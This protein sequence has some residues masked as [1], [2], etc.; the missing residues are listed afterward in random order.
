MRNIYPLLLI[1]IQWSKSFYILA[2][3]K[4]LLAVVLSF[5]M[6]AEKGLKADAWDYTY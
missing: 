2:K 4:N 6:N 3:Y 5:H 1:A